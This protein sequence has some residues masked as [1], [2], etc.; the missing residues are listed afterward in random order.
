MLSTI[1]ARGFSLSFPV[2]G[3]A[4]T[5]QPYINPCNSRVEAPALCVSRYEGIFFKEAK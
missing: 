1:H 4:E 5:C 3:I 2:K